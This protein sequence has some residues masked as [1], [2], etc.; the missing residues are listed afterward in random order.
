MDLSQEELLQMYENMLRI[1]SFEEKAVSLFNEGLIRGPMHVYTGEE[2]IAVGACSNLRPEDYI[3]STHRGHGHCI[4]KG[5]NFK[6]MMAELMGKATGY[7][8]GKGGSMHI[9]D[10]EIGILGANGIVGGGFG[11]A[12]G[13]GLSAKL[14][15]TDQV[16][17][18]FF[19]DGST[20]QGVFHESLNMSAIWD[21]P[22]I[23]LCENNL[24]GLTGPASEMLPITDV[25]DRAKS[26]GIPGEIVDG[27][28]VFAVYNSVKKAIERAKKGKGPT[29]IEAKT[30]RWEGHFVGDPCVYREKSEV[31]EW[32]KKCPLKK[33]NKYLQENDYATGKE[34]DE[35]KEKV[36]AELNEAVEYARK[37]PEPELDILYEDVT[38]SDD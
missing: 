32:K 15:G 7:C 13:A 25:A 30:Y 6:K 27:N 10:L 31:E 36:K 17:I 29:L 21:L 14:R 3:I 5:G 9:A 28:D 24:Y 35:L 22:V 18:C 38:G 19:G 23:Y 20:N 12:P 34:L 4:A 33:F 11:I 37:S 26:Y 16:T 1:R 2:A 8:K